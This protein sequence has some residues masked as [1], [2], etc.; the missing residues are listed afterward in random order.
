M[1]RFLRDRA[2][3]QGIDTVECLEPLDTQRLEGLIFP[4]SG[5]ALY[6]GEITGNGGRRG[7]ISALTPCVMGFHREKSSEERI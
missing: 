6:A 3:K 4:G 7:G 5:S 2:V 1:L